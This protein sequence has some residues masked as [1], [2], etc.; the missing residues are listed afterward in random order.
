MLDVVAPPEQTGKPRGSDILDGTATLPLLYACE[1]DP[2]LAALDLRTVTTPAAAADVCDRIAATG[3]I[4]H[5]EERAREIVREGVAALPADLDE[6]RASAF[7]LMA[8]GVV[9][10][11]L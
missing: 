11:R 1:R 10:R 8:R 5:T 3:A 6:R 9:D 2:E 7:G 4:A